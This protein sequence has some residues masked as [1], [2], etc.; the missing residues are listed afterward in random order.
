MYNIQETADILLVSYATAAKLI[1]DGTIKAVS[2]GKRQR[3][4]KEALIAYVG[5]TEAVDFLLEAY[6]KKLIRNAENKMLK[7]MGIVEK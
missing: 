6:G 7:K 2:I 4:P 3:V 5:Y 1:R